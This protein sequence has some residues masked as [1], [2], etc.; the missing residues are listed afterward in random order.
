MNSYL[1]SSTKKSSG[2]TIFTLGLLRLLKRL[3]YYPSPFKKGPDFIDPLWL[4]RAADRPC[5]NLDFYIS[6][7]SEIKKTFQNNILK[8]NFS[9]V[10]GNKGLFDGMSISG[11]DSN[12]ALAKLLK[13]EVILVLDCT[14]TTRGV[15]PLLNGYKN[16]DKKINFKGVVLNNIAGDRHE[17][18]IIG[19]IQEYT[20]FDVLGSI[21]KNKKLEVLERHLGLE[22]V[23]Q[24]IGSDKIINQ[25]SSI[26]K[27]SINLESILPKKIPKN[28]KNRIILMNNKTKYKNLTIGIAKDK[29]FGFYYPDDLERFESLGIKIK[30][31]DTIRDKKIP[32]VDALFFGGGFPEIV[33]SELSKNI[34]MKSSIFTYI[35][36]DKPVYAECG[37]FMYLCESITFNRKKYKMVGA[38]KGNIMMHKKPIGRGYIKLNI[39]KQHPWFESQTEIRA[40]EFHYSDVK[41]LN[42]KYKFAYDVK[43]GHGINGKKD[44]LIYKNLLASYAHL[45]D[46]QQSQW[47]EKFVKFIHDCKK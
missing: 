46:T 19:S 14:G 28:K 26:I 8:N 37:G 35:D 38:I 27:S 25:I 34:K 4:S 45:R 18:K 7:N 3:G 43:R 24:S 23:F 2:K 30:A 33:A 40:H 15:A 21:Q 1:I 44:G 29:A 10:E 6:S 20:D 39:N 32:N 42:N 41:L 22:P 13:L 16:F 9:I 12:A 47:V 5:Y 36:S 11:S 31:F 17:G